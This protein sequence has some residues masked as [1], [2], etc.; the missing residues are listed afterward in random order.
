MIKVEKPID[1]VNDVLD[2][3]TTNMHNNIK[4]NFLKDRIIECKV[5][6]GTHTAT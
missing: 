6:D 1:K 3:C 4:N 5:S 2:S